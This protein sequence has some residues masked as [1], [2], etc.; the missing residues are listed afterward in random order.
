[1]KIMP[2]NLFA[3]PLVI[4]AST[5]LGASENNVP[6]FLHNGCRILSDGWGLLVQ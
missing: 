4:F 3:D 1:M 5:I 2:N 6:F